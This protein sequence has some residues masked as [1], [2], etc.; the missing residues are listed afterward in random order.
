MTPFLPRLPRA[1][2]VFLVIVVIGT[3]AAIITTA[4]PAAQPQPTAAGTATA[5]VGTTAAP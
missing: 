4:M 1:V 5:P 2:I 3:L